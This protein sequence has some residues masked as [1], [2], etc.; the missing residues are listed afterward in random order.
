[1]DIQPTPARPRRR[2]PS[3]CKCLGR[4]LLGLL[5][6]GILV[7]IAVPLWGMKIMIDKNS[8]PHRDHFY[9][10]TKTTPA[11]V[12]RP[13][14]DRSVDF[15]IVLDIWARKPEN[16]E[17]TD[18]LE[19]N[20]TALAAPEEE[21][22][23]D[24]VKE[25][26]QEQLLFEET[27]WRGVRLG[28][29]ELRQTVKFQ[30]PMERFRN[31]TIN[32]KDVRAT[33]SVIPSKETLGRIQ[34][35]TDWRPEGAGPMQ[36]L[37]Q[38]YIDQ[39][40]DEHEAVQW[41]YLRSLAYSATLIEFHP[42]K[43]RCSSNSSTAE[44]EPSDEID[45]LEIYDEEE[46]SAA[47]ATEPDAE[48]KKV[49]PDPFYHHP[50]LVTR[51]HVYIIDETRNYE[52]KAYDKKHSSLRKRSCG[53][54][55]VPNQTPKPEYCYRDYNV[56]GHW[57]QRLVL[58]GEGGNEEK[59]ELA[60]SP[61]LGLLQHS[62]G[63]KHVVPLP[64]HREKCNITQDGGNSSVLESLFPARC[65][66]LP[67]SPHL[68][69]EEQEYLDVEY[70]LIF[71]TLTAKKAHVLDQFGQ[72]SRPDQHQSSHDLAGI[73]DNWELWNG[74]LGNRAHG[75]HPRRRLVLGTLFFSLLPVYGILNLL[76]WFTRTTTTGLTN[77]GSLML[78]LSILMDNVAFFY[79]A[80]VHEKNDV[81]T[82]ILLS[83]GGLW[84]IVPGILILRLCSPVELVKTGTG[85][86]SWGL[87]RWTLSHRERKN[88]RL[89]EVWRWIPKLFLVLGLGVIDYI[90]RKYKLFFIRPT[91][92]PFDM[93]E[94][95][96]SA[97]NH[98]LVRPP[99]QATL[100]SLLISGQ[101]LQLN[102]NR[103]SGSF[104]G[105]YALTAGIN[106]AA[107]LLH[108]LYFVP[109]ILGRMDNNA[110]FSYREILELAA[111]GVAAWQA[112]TLD[113]VVQ[114]VKDEDEE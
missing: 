64:V 72:H 28:D 85:R 16:G 1:M 113:K 29:K 39:H 88:K 7:C 30:L 45:D 32:T 82:K 44:E 35:Y 83:L 67:K 17:D 63:P 58:Q 20:T 56:N 112:W 74:F 53:Q 25:A 24:L 104:A 40:R 93:A 94:L 46:H 106:L 89:D 41:D 101:L 78:S 114:D 110:G 33:V 42:V 54:R 98:F 10:G 84:D 102:H 97:T 31:G 52:R 68:A 71:S 15:D 21:E 22:P 12:V 14:I 60:Y 9:N 8:N 59:K 26:A 96:S 70:E 47:N 105:Q 19:T 108:L 111:A 86:F 107:Q 73:H 50:H 55:I 11:H 36:R 99:F 38:N 49:V 81:V 61:Y 23:R 57:E 4:T 75:T 109:A 51:S 100:W 34:N 76:Y 77:D 13:F 80:W 65:P 18:A 2:A 66:S 62:A 3:A 87:K 91:S 5:V 43:S 48:T 95:G 37:S 27:L 6:L 79:F 90:C 92:P 103:L 69:F